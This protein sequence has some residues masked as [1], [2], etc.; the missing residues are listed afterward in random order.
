MSA[1]AHHQWILINKTIKDVQGKALL[2]VLE[3][4]KL[5]GDWPRDA[6]VSP[7]VTEERQRRLY[8]LGP[9]VSSDF[10]HAG[11]GK[12]SITMVLQKPGP[13]FSPGS[14]F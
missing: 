4:G 12:T 13:C 14:W 6:H 11:L 10:G 9:T 2:F 8:N 1:R 3:A 7:S 5:P